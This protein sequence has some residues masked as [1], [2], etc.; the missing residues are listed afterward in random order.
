MPSPLSGKTLEAKIRDMFSYWFHSGDHHFQRLDEIH[1]AH[2]TQSRLITFELQLNELAQLLSNVQTYGMTMGKEAKFESL[3]HQLAKGYQALRPFLL[4]YIRLDIED[5]RI[6]LRTIGVGTDA[7][8]AI[9][10]AHSLQSVLDSDDVFFRDRVAR[11]NHAIRD[12]TEHL[13]CLLETSI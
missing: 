12:Y 9:W 5:E 11:A 2:D 10:V 13:L 8:E 4:A 3:K 6:G 1:E 7:F